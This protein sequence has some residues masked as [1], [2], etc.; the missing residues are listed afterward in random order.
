MSMKRRAFIAGLGAAATMPS[1]AHSQE[2]PVVG[3]LHSG[4]QTPPHKGYSQGLADAGYVDGRNITIERRYAEGR[5]DRLTEL[6]SELVRRGV[7]VICAAGGAHTAVAV[8]TASPNIPI[9]FSIGSD[10]VKFGLVI[11]LNHPG[12]N[13]TGVSFFTAEL[14]PKRLGLLHSVV[15]QAT[16]IGALINPTNANAKEQAKDLT[17]AARALGVQLH[18]LHATNESEL[19]AAFVALSERRGNAIVVAS[20]SFFAGRQAEVVS[21]AARHAIPAIYEWREFVDQGGLMSYGPNLTETYRQAGLYTARI[22]HGDKPADIPVTRATKFEFVLNL[23][24]SKALGLA[25]PTSMQLL[26][27]EVIE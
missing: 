9:V 4:S 1:L 16:S 15:P 6:A 23:K 19:E 7:A 25:V 14:E 11:S 2:R 20:D 12:G 13:I 5:Y 22:L 18:V 17:D 3:F 21:L 24:T 26:A 27:D 8:K 10:P